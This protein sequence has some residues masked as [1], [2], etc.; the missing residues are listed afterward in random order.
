VSPIDRDT[1]RAPPLPKAS[2]ARSQ[3]GVLHGSRLFEQP[4]HRALAARI[5]DFTRPDAQPMNVEIGI[6]R[7]YRLLA[8]ARRWPD[9]RWLGLEIRRTIAAAAEGA[10]AN[11]LV[12]RADA[13]AVFTTLLID[14]SLDRVDILFPSPSDDPGH[15]LLT[16]TFVALLG[17]RLR[18][19]GRVHL[20]SDLPGMAELIATRFATWKPAP[21]PPS[22]P[23]RS[24]RE[25]A[26]ERE[27]LRVWRSTFVSP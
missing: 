20:A 16:P 6:D 18:P 27:G 15:L 12:V 21:E 4:E 9:E 23:V 3:R 22:G 14:D 25:V 1:W 8:H 10:P 2:D 13:R 5:R 7:G 26:C 24:R 19:G 17:A 11:A